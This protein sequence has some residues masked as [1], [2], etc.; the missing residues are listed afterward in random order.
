[1]SVR[2]RTKVLLVTVL[3][4]VVTAVI[5]AYVLISG[6]IDELNKRIDDKGN[7]ITN[8]LSV[9][10]EYGL[11]SNSFEYL[12][13]I[14]A[15]TI[16]QQD[17]VAIYI[18]DKEKSIVL[19]R[20]N[21]SYKN[22][23]IRDFDKKRF[24][25][26]ASDIIKTSIELDDIRSVVE[27]NTGAEN[28]TRIDNIIGTVNIVMD[29]KN[30]EL[31]K[32]EIVRNGIFVTLILTLVTIFIAI[33]FSRSVT[34]PISQIYKDV[35]VIKQGDL[36]HR[37]TVNFSGELAELASGINKMTS[38]LEMAHNEEQQRNE[39]LTRANK[40]AECANRA[41]SLFLSSMSHEMRTPLNAIFGFSQLIE[42]DAEA[43]DIKNNAQEII[44]SSRHLLEMIEGLLDISQIE[45]GNLI[46]NIRSESLKDILEFCLSMV[47]PSAEEKALQL[48]NK[49][50]LLPDVKIEV[51]KKL[52]KQVLLNILSNAIK[53]NIKNGSVIIDYSL[54]NKTMLCLSVTDTGTGIEPQN[55]DN[56]FNYFDRAGQ[57]CSTITGSGLGL[58]ISKNLI[59]KMKGVIEFESTVGEGSCFKI[60]VPIS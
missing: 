14:L 11:F 34:G 32:T 15:H 3:P 30:T 13:S 39:A 52:F 9:T 24:K 20:L 56:I 4:V 60:K 50:D 23:N 55:Y 10:S 45:S 43:D 57:E 36:K 42:F 49:V 22:I 18:E 58:A 5:L 46:L 17:I 33:L 53:Y 19:K 41:K 35:N 38:S 51:D 28:I 1:M 12:E 16:N 40:E 7:D 25:G 54:E 44:R 21:G 48:E 6:R 26:F 47:K 27:E 31:L 2:F 59:E 37:I 29:L 8:Y